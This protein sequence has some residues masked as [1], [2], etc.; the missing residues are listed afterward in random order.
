MS[1]STF[2]LLLVLGRNRWGLSWFIWLIICSI[3]DSMRELIFGCFCNSGLVE[4]WIVFTMDCTV[5][6]GT[7]SMFTSFFSATFAISLNV[8][9]YSY[10]TCCRSSNNKPMVK[11][12]SINALI[13]TK[14]ESVPSWPCALRHLWSLFCNVIVFSLYSLTDSKAPYFSWLNSSIKF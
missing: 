12:S 1:L 11:C 14:I 4:N 2:L 3:A 6:H 13:P 9:A 10:L 5:G 7:S 8:I